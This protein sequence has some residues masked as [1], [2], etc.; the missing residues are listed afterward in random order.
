M[1]LQEGKIPC[2]IE[3]QVHSA[4]SYCTSVDHEQ[5]VTTDTNYADKL[6]RQYSLNGLS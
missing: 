2:H 4:T 6:C 1:E 5:C 3:T